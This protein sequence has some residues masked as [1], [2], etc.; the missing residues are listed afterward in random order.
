MQVMETVHMVM[1]LWRNSSTMQ[2]VRSMSLG[3]C[4]IPYREIRNAWP[5]PTVNT[6]P[7][8]QSLLWAIPEA[9]KLCSN[10]RFY[11]SDAVLNLI[12][13]WEISIPE[14]NQVELD[15]HGHV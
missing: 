1:C 14:I 2:I 8:D 4:S 3:V 15:A 10:S 12:L 9:G 5:M 6:F 13:S 11:T 7:S